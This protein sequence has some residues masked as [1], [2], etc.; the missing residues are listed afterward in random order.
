[1]PKS[2]NDLDSEKLKTLV[3]LGINDRKYFPKLEDLPSKWDSIPPDAPD[4]RYPEI[5]WREAQLICYLNWS[6]TKPWAWEGLQ[7]SC[8]NAS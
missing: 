8:G 3:R 6:E 1:M 4:P 2:R 5:S 7:A